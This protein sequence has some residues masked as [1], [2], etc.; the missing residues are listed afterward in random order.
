MG[1]PYITRTPVRDPEGFYGREDTLKRIF[2]DIGRK[3]M[4]SHCIIG[5]RRIGKTSLSHQVAHPSIQAKYMNPEPYLFLRTDLALFPDASPT[6]FFEEWTTGISTLT[7]HPPPKELGY[8]TFRT[9]IR[10]VTETGRKVV[11]V[12][13]EFESVIYNK[14]IDKEIFEFLRSLTQNYDISFILFSRVPFNRFL[15]EEKF[16]SVYSSPFFNAINISYLK[17]LQESEA[18]ALVIEPAQKEGVDLSG[19]VDFILEQAYY[20]PFLLQTLSSIA[21]DHHQ[22]G[23]M[24]RESMLKE[25]AVQTEEFFVSLWNYSDPEEKEALRKLASHNTDV[26]RV[27]LNNLDRRSLLIRENDNVRLFCPSFEEFVKGQKM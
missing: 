27:V 24:S 26:D 25:F 11:I 14:N 3:H 21:F 1:N 16:R 19:V 17:F 4:Q 12:L 23:N 6:T 10:E 15:R 2:G 18:R 9:F 8:L 13:D 20:H 5:E 7:G 22:S